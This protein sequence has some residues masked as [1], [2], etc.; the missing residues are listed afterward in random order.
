MKSFWVHGSQWIIAVAAIVAV[1]IAL[2]EVQTAQEDTAEQLKLTQS[3]LEL[4]K[5]SAEVSQRAWVLV[6]GV[7]FEEIVAEK[8][9]KLTLLIKNVGASPAIDLW[10]INSWLAT[11]TR[12]PSQLEINQSDHLPSQAVLG[13]GEKTTS[14]I[15]TDPIPTQVFTKIQNGAGSLLVYGQITYRDPLAVDRRTTFRAIYN[16]KTKSFQYATSGNTIE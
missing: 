8:P 7:G 11:T 12:V 4:A 3:S 5:R 10:L 9:L 15:L 2:G 16:P 1:I 13:P 6:T 14:S